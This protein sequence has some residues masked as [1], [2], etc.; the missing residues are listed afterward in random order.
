MK[1][2]YIVGAGGFGR[3]LFAWIKRHPD[4]ERSW[5]IAG[6]IDD[7]PRA[8]DTF[9][10]PVGI[11]GS[12]QDHQPS[13][14]NCYICAIGTPAIKKLV[15]ESL[16]AKGAEFISFIHPSVI[17]GANSKLGRGV[18][19]CPRVT[20]TSDVSIG[21]FALI[22][23]HSSAGHDVQVSDWVTVSGHCD[24]TGGCLIGEAAFLATGV[25][26]IP[27]SSIGAFAF[28]GAGSVVIKSVAA[29]AKVF[30]N[31]AKVFG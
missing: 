8:L 5:R 27:N 30:G 19:L 23:C 25:R 7:N 15:C 21:N 26:I 16:E 9:D 22:N 4:Y 12:I 2:L 3:E 29:N 18:V 17:I 14:E 28:V 13:Q 6:F 10:Y 1:N 20:L 31:P 24:L 11:E